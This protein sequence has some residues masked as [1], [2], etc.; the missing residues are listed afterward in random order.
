MTDKRDTFAKL[1]AIIYQNDKKN[2][3]TKSQRLLIEKKYQEHYTKV[4]TLDELYARVPEVAC[5]ISKMRAGRAE[6]EH[7]LNIRKGLQPGILNECVLLETLAT[8]LGF[9]KFIDLETTAIADIPF[10]IRDNLN[11]IQT[12]AQTGCAARYA[13][14]KKGDSGNMLFQYGNPR[15]IGDAT[16]FM[17]DCE[18]ILEIKD[19]PALIDD[20]DL[21]YD[22]DGKFIIT[23]E[24][25]QE[26]PHFVAPIEEF[27]R[28]S[29]IF[30]TFGHNYPILRGNTL[31]EHTAYLEAVLNDP[32]M[33]GLIT[34]VDDEL[35]LIRKEDLN[36]C[37]EDGEYLLNLTGS[38]IRTLG[39][40]HK[41]VFTPLYLNKVLE[42]LDIKVDGDG[43]CVTSK[44]NPKL[45]GL[46]KGRNTAGSTRL[47]L[48]NC[49]FLRVKELVD[50]HDDL[51][52]FKK[53]AIQQSKAGISV[54]INIAKNK[55]Y[56]KNKVYP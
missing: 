12:K 47:R 36:F 10:E 53:S 56:I 32:R 7:Q 11:R 14:Y 37:C 25:K 39:K 18:I 22:E 52:H 19:L 9:R 42:E 15:A 50:M 29:D 34:S 21:V 3:L 1:I 6:I 28:S 30:K 33:D 41:K 46:K 17:D 20:L 26:H 44:I 38:E 54:H 43:M 55:N 51:L 8:Y 27:N 35:I 31:G 5:L 49:F 24:L 2:I 13:Y 4:G 48:K 23:E 45:E 40:N 16:L